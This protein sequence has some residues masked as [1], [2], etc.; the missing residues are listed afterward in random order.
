MRVVPAVKNNSGGQ[1]ESSAARGVKFPAPVGRRRQRRGASGAGESAPALAP[2]YSKNFISTTVH[3]LSTELSH[4]GVEKRLNC[5]SIRHLAVTLLSGVLTESDLGDLS[6]LMTHSQAMA[7]STYND[8]MKWARMARISTI[9][10]KILTKQDLCP[11]D[12]VKAIHGE[13]R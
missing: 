6:G 10:N 3:A 11:E 4:A 2:E 12:L 9:A 13:N 7:E 8:S 1:R 5:T